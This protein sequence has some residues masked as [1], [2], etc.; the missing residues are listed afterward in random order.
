VQ[1]TGALLSGKDPCIVDVEAIH[2]L[3]RVYRINHYQSVRMYGQKRLHQNAI[4]SRVS[5]QP[6]KQCHHTCPRRHR[7][8]P[9]AKVCIPIATVK[10]CLEL[11]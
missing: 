7:I 5:V 2:I 11:T 8:K 4:P 9:M 1:G 10:R 3:R 6:T